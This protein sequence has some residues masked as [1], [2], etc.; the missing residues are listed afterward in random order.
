MTV[1]FLYTFG[2]AFVGF[3]VG[4]SLGWRLGRRELRAELDALYR[5]RILPY[6][7]AHVEVG[8]SL[9]DQEGER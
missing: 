7:D 3:G 4:Y 5:E 2:V 9:Y 1:L 8:R 6:R